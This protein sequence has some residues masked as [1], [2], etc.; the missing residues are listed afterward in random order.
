VRIYG[1]VARPELNG[2]EGTVVEWDDV[3]GRWKVHSDSGAGLM[4]RAAN[5]EP[6][7][8]L[9]AVP[10]S[11]ERRVPQQD[12]GIL[13]GMHVRIHGL[14]ARPE[15][16]GTEG[17][18]VEW[19]DVEERWKVNF[20]AFG[21]RCNLC[22][23]SDSGAGLMLRAAN[24][25]PGVTLP[26]VPSSPERRVPQQDSGIL[27]GMHVRIHGLMARPELNGTEGTVVEWDDVEER[28][29]VHSDS[30]AGLML[31]AANL[32]PGVTLPAVPSSPERRV[33][34]SCSQFSV[35][36]LRCCRQD[37]GILPG[38]H[39]RIHGLMARPE[40]NETEG[41]VVE[42]DDVEERWKVRSD[43]GA[44]LM[45]RAANLEPC[46]TLPAVPSSP[47]RRAPQQ[48]S[49]ILPGMHVRIHGLKARPELNGTEGTVVEWDDV[50]ERWKVQSDSGA[51]LMLR[52]AN[53]EPCVT[54][55][56]VPSS[57]VRRVPQQDSGILPGMHV[58][59]HGLK[60]RPELN[61]TEGTVV[62]WDDVEERWK[63]HSDSGAG[64]M[65]RAAN[66]KPG[67]TLP[68]VPSSPERRA[69]QQDSG[70]LPGMHVR[71]HGLKA[72]PE[73]NGTEGTVVE[74]DDV[75][76]RWKVQSDSGAGLMLR[77]ANLEPC[78]TL[79]AV[80]S[81]P[82]RRV[83]QQDSG[84]LPGMHVRIHG[85]KARP[86]LNGTEGTVVEWDDVE[87]RWKVHSDSGAGLM[88]RA[89][90]L[91]P[92]VTLPAVPSSPERRA[93]QQDS[94]I[95]PGMHVRIHGLMARPEL[96]E[97]EGTVVEWDDVEER[98]KVHSDSGAGLMLRAANLKPG[99]TLP[100]VP[101]APERR[102][103]QSCSQQ[104]SGILPGMHVR[105]HGLMARP[106]LNET[107]GTVVEW[108]DGEQRWKVRLDSGAGL[109]L[110][111]ANLESCNPTQSAPSSPGR[112]VLQ[113]D[114]GIS[115]GMRVRIHGLMAR[116]ELNGTEGT[117]VE[118]DDGEERWKVRLD[119]GAGL[120]LKAANL[121]SCNPTQSAPSSPGRLVLQKDS[122][123]SP[124]MRVRIR[125]LMARPELNGTEGTVAEWDDGEQR[126]KVRSDSGTGLMLKAANLESC[127]PLQSVPS[128]PERLVLQKDSGISPG[129]RVRIHGLMA[130]PELNGTEGTVVE[131]DDGEQRWKVIEVRSDSGTGL[132]LRAANLESC[133]P[134]QSAP[135][136][137][138]RPVL[139][140]ASVITPGRRVFI[141]GLVARP[142]LNGMEGM[143]V[144]WDDGEQRW[145]VA[146]DNGTG[147]TLKPANLEPPSHLSVGSRVRICNLIGRPELNGCHGV[148][149]GWDEDESRWKV[150]M[151]DGSRK[152]FRPENTEPAT[153]EEPASGPAI[154]PGSRVRVGGLQSRTDLNGCM[155]T[156][157]EWDAAEGRW[158]VR[159]DDGSGK[160][161]TSDNLELVGSFLP[162]AE[163]ANLTPAGPAVAPGSR[164]RVGGLQLRPDLNGCIGTAVE[165]DVAEGRWKVRMDDGS[166][167][168]F[169]SDNLELVNASLQA[170]GSANGPFAVPLRPGSRVS[171]QGLK[172][173]PDLN[174]STGTLV[175]WDDAE[176]R[177]KVRLDDGSGK[178]FR[179]DNLQAVS[180]ATLGSSAQTSP[181]VASRSATG[182]SAQ[183][184][185]SVPSRSATGLSVASRSAA[186]QS[187]LGVGIE[188]GER[189]R[190]GGLKA[191]PDLN[192]CLGT[193]V[194]WDQG[195]ARWKAEVLMDDGS[196]K[197]LRSS[198]LELSSASAV[199]AS[200][201]PPM[202]SS[203]PAVGSAAMPS[204]L[205]VGIEA[206]ERVRVGGLK[207]R[208]DLNGCL[209]T[210][211]EWDQGEARWKVLMDDGS[212]K[213]LRSS[214]L[215]LSSASAVTASVPPPMSS[216]SPAVGSAAMPSGPAASIAPGGRIRVGGLQARPD[217]NGCLG[218]VLN[219]D[220]TED[221]WK[222]RMDNGS[223]KMFKSRNLEV[224]GEAPAQVASQEAQ[225]S[226]A[227]G[228]E[229]GARVRVG[230][231]KSRAELNGC[232]G[233]V[234][235]WDQAEA[236]WK[237]DMDDG[238]GKM[239]KA[240]NLEICES[241]PSVAP[242]SPVAEAVGVGSFV[243][244][245]GLK[246][247]PELNGSHGTATEWDIGQ[248]RWKVVMEDG[249][250]KMFRPA[251]LEVCV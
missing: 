80:P 104:D 124:G 220:E 188:A 175:E 139:Q 214:N 173:R 60:A 159:M 225:C 236:R 41:T 44:G 98:W 222:V 29:K 90:N 184:P 37:S 224:C 183:T 141:K 201:P 237:V 161:F 176:G 128:S 92:G 8:T 150:E 30:G 221:R 229:A 102:V 166:G 177:W 27:P 244:V 35:F 87:E 72:R 230:G 73:L 171:V 196:G 12:S 135:S 203:S 84:I 67:V 58:R 169:K 79:P 13:P 40:L 138:G 117:V 62:E 227:V 202:S 140:A 246:G 91:E 32:E 95:L 54:L 65:L 78:V 235:D 240:G 39:V 200:V 82:V 10:S 3:E 251:N 33:P 194:E 213:M 101:S 206:G 123:I 120:M 45:L 242:V 179:S 42:W 146:A 2:T 36:P 231:L 108:D 137:P 178:M 61:G 71:I 131:W 26:A 160:M 18:V 249:S 250:G 153:A 245:V 19:D 217:L 133:N 164:V 191:R 204:G 144:D 100:A 118:W 193:V 187:G 9:P 112:L 111:A 52:A 57:P 172:A 74:W 96:N 55:P 211:V 158:K 89:A 170:A 15:L 94:G 97:T 134:L 143:V 168:M 226:A 115:P 17:T 152:S 182:Q 156:A 165:W 59:I 103:P 77:A 223:G 1:L 66:L 132:M 234:A 31:R 180:T 219:W 167:M 215:E 56:A 181:P 43:S 116:P 7:V 208:P 126:W 34:Q 136:S 129:M 28:W 99:V 130:R 85:L 210:V 199:T 4:L 174:G 155:G 50:E 192:G 147:L 105:I 241:R 209:G 205:G 106:E 114:S 198:N 109:M 46:V 20:P 63:V 186:A 228:I 189:V 190:V 51:G 151:D 107:E 207:A 197:M 163:Y 119:S 83:P 69:P 232:L 238:S 233:T 212:G 162:A 64:L 48:D 248:A 113:K 5:L 47:E 122:G 247:R 14:M 75:E 24:L 185:P 86:E 53:L 142:E 125:G 110:K 70:I 11:P 23:C 145:K 81:S 16:N 88:L 49:G 93:P 157:V 6:C 154:S 148:V 25:E 243:R 218:T 239:L 216:S 76:E 121:E 127:N 195:E 22:V 68:A 149:G 38:M 21:C